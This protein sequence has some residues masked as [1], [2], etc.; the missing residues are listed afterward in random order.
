MLV[1]GFV[2]LLCDAFLQTYCHNLDHPLE[3]NQQ[4][5]LEGEN[6]ATRKTVIL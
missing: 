5:S 2:V 3:D 1:G 6:N 4:I